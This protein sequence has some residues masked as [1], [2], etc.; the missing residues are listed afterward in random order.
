MDR[1]LRLAVRNLDLSDEKLRYQALRELLEAS[2]V[3]VDWAYGVWNDFAARLKH[4]SSYQ[5]TIGARLLCN[6]A[7]SDPEHRLRALLPVLLRLTRD[8]KFVT[9]R[10]VLQNIW[11]P[12]AADAELRKKIVDHLAKQYRSCL[13]GKHYNLIRQDILQSLRWLYDRVP[14]EKLRAKAM[15]L[16]VTESEPKYRKKYD[17]IWK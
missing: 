9:A 8:E 16:I 14:D 12:A 17:A 2:E 11:K 5:R 1:N 15:S 4:E 13:G 10:Q 6:L 7:G 3:K